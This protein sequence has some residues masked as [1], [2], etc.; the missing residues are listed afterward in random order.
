MAWRRPALFRRPA[1]SAPSCCL[2]QARMESAAKKNQQTE[3]NWIWRGE[4]QIANGEKGDNE[5]IGECKGRCIE[6]EERNQRK[7]ST[8]MKWEKGKRTLFKQTDTDRLP[9]RQ[10]DKLMDTRLQATVVNRQ[11]LATRP[12]QF[13]FYSLCERWFPEAFQCTAGTRDTAWELQD[14]HARPLRCCKPTARSASE[15][16]TTVSAP[17]A[18][19]GATTSCSRPSPPRAGLPPPLDFCCWADS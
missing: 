17:R 8:K 4:G 3:D 19:S 5:G 16:A 12:S 9:D 6:R 10:T 7:E 15:E 13:L 2:H 18:T 14:A 1:C 11:K